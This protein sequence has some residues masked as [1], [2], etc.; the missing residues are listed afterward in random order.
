TASQVAGNFQVI[1]EARIIDPYTVHFILSAPAPWLPAQMAA[2]LVMLPPDYAAD[3][4]NDFASRPVGTGPFR[5]LAWDRGERVSLEA[6][7][8]YFAASPKGQP[9]AS[10]VEFRFVPEAGTRVADLLSGGTDLVVTVPVDQVAA[11]ENGDAEVVSQALSGTAFVRIATDFAPFA[12]ARVRQALNYAVDVEAIIAAL[13]AGNGSRL[14]N[15]YPDE[16]GLGFDPELAP[17]SYD[18]D[19][20]RSL[21]AEAGFSDGFDTSLEYATAERQEVVEAIAGQLEDIGVRVELQRVETAT[22]NQTWSAPTSAPLR[23][24]TWRPLFDP[25]TLLGL[26]VATEGFLSRHENPEVQELIDAAAVETDDEARDSLYRELGVVLHEQP[27]AIYLYNLTELYGVTAA[28]A[29][30]EP[31]ADGYVIPTTT[32]VR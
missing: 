14:A 3:P 11:V 16:R 5:F 4:A 28:V 6:N 24:V 12:D 1:D 27:A 7:L 9:L 19:R 30:W 21:L 31:R 32:G 18:P 29:N 20:A 2:W 25:Y 23:F 26:V 22:F 8:D 13:Q 15:L 17:Y 10:G